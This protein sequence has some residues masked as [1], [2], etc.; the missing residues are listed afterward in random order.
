MKLYLLN[1]YPINIF[2]DYKYWPPEYYELVKSH[3]YNP[4]SL[5]ICVDSKEEVLDL[6]DMRH[7]ETI[8]DMDQQE[9]IDLSPKRDVFN[10]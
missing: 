5:G 1:N 10:Q 8:M 3:N 4:S 6:I 9:E 7:H 2:R